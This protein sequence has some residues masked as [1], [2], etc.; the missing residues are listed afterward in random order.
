MVMES[1]VVT[2]YREDWR[3]RLNPRAGSCTPPTGLLRQLCTPHESALIREV[4]EADGVPR[5][6][7]SLIGRPLG[8]RKDQVGI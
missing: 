7:S 8:M 5:A 2:R 4:V 1:Q 6:L 3:A